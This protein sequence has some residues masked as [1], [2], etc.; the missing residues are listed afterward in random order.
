ME[1]IFLLVWKW[2]LWVMLFAFIVSIIIKRHDIV[3]I[4]W[5]IAITFWI[6]LAYWSSMTESIYSSLLLILFFAWSIRLSWYIL[7]KNTWKTEDFR[8][9]KWR[10]NWGRFFYLRSF[11]QV[12]MLQGAIIMILL[13]P[14]INAFVR[15]SYNSLLVII[16]VTIW[17]L[18]FYFEYRADYELYSFKSRK[19]N[20]WKLFTWWLR[21]YSRHPN[22]FWEFLMWWWIYIFTFNGFDYSIVSPLLISFLLLFVSGIPMLEKKWE[23]DTEFIKYKKRV[24]SFFPKIKIKK[25]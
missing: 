12:F 14:V 22:Y 24:P 17:I 15:D 7:V 16:G 20:K 2:I 10:N 25:N 6:A 8:Y 1:W 11:L 4:F 13:I 23:G 21:Q 3:D 18:W 9:A 5:W 19:H